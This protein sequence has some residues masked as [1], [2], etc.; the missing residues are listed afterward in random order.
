MLRACPADGAT[1][2]L[3]QAVYDWN[4]NV[5]LNESNLIEAMELRPR[6]N[7]APIELWVAGTNLK[8]VAFN[9]SNWPLPQ[10]P[11]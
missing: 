6:R 3:V 7:W 5:P 1:A 9:C 8:T 10:E 2:A 4:K 11:A